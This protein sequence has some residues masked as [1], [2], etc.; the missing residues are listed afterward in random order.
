[1][2]NQKYSPEY[3]L[4]QTAG[5]RASLLAVLIFTVVNLAMLLL[6]TGTY[7]LFSAS[8]PFFLT[9]FA[10]GMDQD[11][12]YLGLTSNSIG[13]YTYIALVISA[14]ILVLYLLCWLLGKKFPGWLIVAL[15]FFIIDTVVLLVVSLLLEILTENILDLVFHG[16]IVFQLIQG[17]SAN[18][19]L[20]KMIAEFDPSDPDHI[21]F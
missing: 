6:N 2:N 4:K 12:Y 5:A 8:V 20:E 16:L 14:V 3:L 19:K 7:F 10:W 17:I 11:M 9:R 1:M 15:V 21:S 13:M 18:Y